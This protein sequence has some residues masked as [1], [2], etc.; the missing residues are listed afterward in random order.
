[1]TKL[2]V[3]WICSE[4][5][6][7]NFFRS[8]QPYCAVK[9]HLKSVDP[10]IVYYEPE[11]LVR[12][13]WE[14]DLYTDKAFSARADIAQAVGWA[15]VVVWMG[16]HSP[17]S[18]DLFKW[19]RLRYPHVKMIMEIDDFL[20]SSAKSNPAA[21]EVYRYGGDLAKIGLEQMRLS[22]GLIVSTPALAE[23]YKPYAKKIFVV[24]NVMDLKLWPKRKK[25]KQFTVGWIGAGS[26]DDDLGLLRN[27]VPR[28]LEKHSNVQFSIVHGTPE[29]FKHKPGCEYLLNPRHPLYKKM[30]KC[31]KCKGLDRV[32][33]THDFKTIDK[34]PKWAASFGFDIGLA[35]L[36]DINFTRG[37]SNLRWL[38]Y[39]AMGIPTVASPLNH[40]KES[41]VDGK[42]GLIVEGNT[43]DGWFEA[44]DRLIVDA[45][46][47][48]R[49]G[50]AAH[51]EVKE[52]WNLL[53][54]AKKYKRAIEG[55]TNA[56][57][58]AGDACF[59]NQPIGQ[60]SVGSE[61]YCGSEAG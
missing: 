51:K 24:E 30:R 16:L 43:E 19:C 29:F 27:V 37:K 10:A 13:N 36:V 17:A 3:L 9:N 45:G 55:I 4:V 49:I 53:S 20:L 23:M 58:D 15:D 26:H 18:L 7:V 39:S 8:Y 54:M 46:L 57:H 11:L 44:I 38:E 56:E 1:M 14:Y 22:D 5:G 48:E 25:N 34:Y 52:N 47:R 41:I 28:I 33:W 31:P 61:V 35:P 2:N 60:R 32:K 50:K 6:G 59:S 21:G 40:F 12:K 42:T